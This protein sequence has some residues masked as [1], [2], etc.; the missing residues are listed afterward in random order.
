MHKTYLALLAGLAFWAG[1]ALSALAREG[2]T[3]VEVKSDH[4]LLF[5][6]AGEDK[7]E[8]LVR[9]LERF[10]AVVG[11]VAGIDFTT[12]P[13]RPLT[14]FAYRRS[15]DY[16]RR[17]QAQ[18]TAG[19]Y[20]TDIEG[21]VAALTVESGKKKWNL[22]GRQVI[23][24]EYTHHL[25]HHYSPYI[26]PTWYDEGFAE[27]LATTEFDGDEAKIGAPAIPRFIALK[28]AGHW[29][30][31]RELVEAKGNYIGQMGTGLLRDRR[32]GWSGTQFQ[33][34]Q[35][36][37]LT[38]FL[39]NSKRFRPGITKYIVALNT[40][41][42]DEKEAFETAFGVT[43]SEMDDEVRKY[44]GTRELPYFRV[45][46][47]GRIPSFRIE[48]R[49]LSPVE[50]AAVD[51][52]ARLLTGQP[53]GTGSAARKAFEAMRAAGIRVEDMT[54]YLARIAM[55]DERW[56][57]A[58]AEV[59]RLLASNGKNARGLVAKATLLRA[60]ASKEDDTLSVAMRKKVRSLCV[61]AIRADP[62]YV[63]AL[64]A[65]ADLTLEE[66]GPASRTTEKIIAS[67]NYL[68][69]EIEEGRILEA[70]ML[71]K[72]GEIE[73]ARR[74]IS[75]MMSWAAGIRERKKYER[76]LEELEALAEKAKSG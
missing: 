49:T 24:H 47:K 74:R 19:F 30:P 51:Y 64:L 37:L 20:H 55:E 32:R 7:A 69:P 59:D 9:D 14:I 8:A 22:K 57:D 40:P 53:G 29:L 12:V 28:R 68:A 70:K 33:Y 16:V 75:L 76:L 50:A 58:L 15:A 4:F 6:D 17:L 65:Y 21:D 45:N 39:N 18:G 42:V 46:L 71:A 25:L 44:W 60:R 13:D 35:G 5:S 61:Q 73:E 11:L 38:H 3:W 31:L 2:E 10:R 56:D 72:K 1:L 66:D 23:F 34:A 54:L 27:Y 62:T 63:P 43:Y 48:T 41:G 52:E 36:W 67:V 26:Y